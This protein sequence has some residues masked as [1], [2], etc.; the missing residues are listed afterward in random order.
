[1]S[2]RRTC[3]VDLSAPGD[4]MDRLFAELQ[5]YAKRHKLPPAVVN[6]VHLALDEMVSNVITYGMRG[7]QSCKISVDFEL[8]P[9]ELEIRL[10]DNGK[11]FDPLQRE[12]PDTT[13]P[14]EDRQIGGLGI[15]FVKKLM[16]DVRYTRADRMNHLVMIKKW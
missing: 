10:S 15:L 9:K 16:T 5:H 8:R 4:R 2:V 6:V 3:H 13:L 1:M 11:A 12:D 14:L 7:K